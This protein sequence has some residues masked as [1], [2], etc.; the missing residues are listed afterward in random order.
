MEGNKG[1]LIGYFIIGIFLLGGIIYA[2]IHN[3]QTEKELR[4]YDYV[5]AVIIDKSPGRSHSNIYVEY[6]YKKVRIQSEFSAETD[7]F[8]LG[9]KVLLKISKKYPDKYIQLMR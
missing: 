9:Q 1:K 2:V 7:T 6:T 4:S 5:N 3:N 8:K